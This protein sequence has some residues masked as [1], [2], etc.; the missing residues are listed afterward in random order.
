LATPPPQTTAQPSPLDL[1]IAQYLLTHPAL[2]QWM[3]NRRDAYLNSIVGTRLVQLVNILRGAQQTALRTGKPADPADIEQ[4]LNSVLAGPKIGIPVHGANVSQIGHG[5][6][7]HEDQTLHGAPGGP[8]ESS[9]GNVGQTE[10]SAAVAGAAHV[11]YRE[12]GVA[13]HEWVT[14]EDE[15]VC[16]IC[17]A[18]ETAGPIT[19]GL[20]FPSGDL[21]PPAHPRCRC[22]TTP[23]EAQSVEP[24]VQQREQEPLRW[25]GWPNTSLEEEVRLQNKSL[26]NWWLHK[27]GP[28][29]YIH[30]WIFVGY[31]SEGAGM[32]VHHPDLGSGKLTELSGP[33][34]GKRVAHVQFDNGEEHSFDLTYMSQ[35]HGTREDLAVGLHPR[36]APEPKLNP[37]VTRNPLTGRLGGTSITPQQLRAVQDYIGPDQNA[38]INGLLRGNVN[39][40]PTQESQDAALADIKTLDDLLARHTVTSRTVTYRGVALTPALAAQ[41]KPGSTFTDKAYVSSSTSPVWAQRFAQLRSAGHTEGIPVDVPAAGGVPTLLR[42]TIPAGSHMVPGEPEIGEFILPR[43]STFHVDKVSPSLISLSLTGTKPGP[44]ISVPTAPPSD[45]E[46]VLRDS[47]TKVASHTAAA[48]RMAWTE[49]EIEFTAIKNGPGDHEEEVRLQNK[50]LA[51]YWLHKVGPKGYI[52]GWIYV[53]SPTGVMGR[54]VTHPVHGTGKIVDTHSPVDERGVVSGE[55]TVTVQ[56]KDGTRETYGFRERGTT[57]EYLSPGLQERPTS[58]PQ[59]KPPVSMSTGFTM[60]ESEQLTV[61]QRQALTH[62]VQPDSNA[63]ING[64]LRGHVVDYQP[65]QPELDRAMLDINTMDK[66]LTAHTLTSPATTYRGIAL[67]PALRAQMKPGATFTDKAY[68]STTTS[69]DWARKFAQM[70]ATG[71]A[72][73]LPEVAS[74]GGT[75]TV[76][77]LSIPTGSHMI[78]GE[79]DIGEYVLP[80][81]SSFRVDQVTPGQISLSY[82]G[83][84]APAVKMPSLDQQA[85]HIAAVVMGQ[86][87][88][89]ERPVHTRTKAANPR[90]AAAAQRMAWAEDE[91]EFGP[92]A[93]NG[94]GASE[95]GRM[96]GW[97]PRCEGKGCPECEPG[98]EE[99]DDREALAKCLSCGCGLPHDDHGDKRNITLDDVEAAGTAM[100]IA[101]GQAGSNIADWF[102]T[103]QVAAAAE[104]PNK[105]KMLELPDEHGN[106]SGLWVAKEAVAMLSDYLEKKNSPRGSAQTLRDYWSGH[107]HSGPSHGAFEHAIAWGTPGDF[108]RCVAMVTEHAKMSP[109]HAKGYCN[110]RHHDALGIYPATHAKDIR[111]GEGKK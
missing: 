99:V 40:P 2:A 31:G 70:R 20:P 72:E 75:P 46:Q 26:A 68:V 106:P 95:Y 1:L 94:A 86:H 42:V 22:T 41:L 10:V 50:T 88:S 82:L 83:S 38:L 35:M 79:P 67:T 45:L 80:R 24:Y 109:D 103:E 85:S 4:Q 96:P 43:G 104:P 73:N 25:W 15:K 16:P 69:L 53:G 19:L 61:G 27:V 5:Q 14:A 66:L 84:A 7:T 13:E 105:P 9:A 56:Y 108:D 12:A 47:I 110:L 36:P 44:I 107:G 76:L 8:A 100:D 71:H 21:I 30:G 92:V 74:M 59:L 11:V 54:H 87:H 52:H 49:D 65:D 48:Q 78:P 102:R 17:A 6:E 37:R 23:V 3:Q 64:T 62:Y 60:L 51:S 18:N 34:G 89:S 97:C 77:K 81:S 111:E 91:I 39:H 101:P 28:K 93:K 90:H 98:D 63:V 58:P 57:A 32:S 29:G 55:Q 33:P